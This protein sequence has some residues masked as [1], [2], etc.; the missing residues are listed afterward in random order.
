MKLLDA[1]VLRRRYFLLWRLC[2][3][4]QLIAGDLRLVQILLKSSVVVCCAWL[5]ALGVR[6]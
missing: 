4:P 1:F 2:S 6:L 3:Y 5:K